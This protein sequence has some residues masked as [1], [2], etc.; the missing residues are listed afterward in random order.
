MPEDLGLLI[1]LEIHEQLKTKSKLFCT[2]S[3][4]YRD[5]E[6][7]HNI[8][9]VC[10]AQPGSKPMRLNAQALRNLLKIALALEC[11]IS[12][13]EEIIIQRKHYFYPDLPSNYQRTSEPIGTKGKLGNVRIRELHIEE[14]P[15]RY[16]L[17]KGTVDYNRSGVPLVEIVTEPDIR[18]PED[19]RTFLDELQA[20]TNYLCATR[21]EPGSTRIDANISLRGG[22]RVEVKNINSY[23]GV[24][25]ALKYEITRQKSLLE[26]GKEVVRETR[27]FD[28]VQGITTTL[29]KKEEVADY[30]YIPDPDVLPLLITAKEVQEISLSLPELPRAK[31]ERISQEYKIR[32]DDAWVLS[33]EKELIDAYETLAKS[34]DAQKLAF[35]MRGILKKQL[36][37]RNL[38]FAQSGLSVADLNAIAKKLFSNEITEDVAEQTLINILDKKGSIAQLAE[39]KV[40]A[41]AKELER[42]IF[43]LLDANPK[44]VQDYKRGEAKALNALSGLV[45][46][47]TQGRAD[48]R[49]VM[50]LLKKILG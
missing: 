9:A 44:I 37:Y 5:A 6:P 43:S 49:K 50:E 25:T 12:T 42:I 48:A 27:H 20:I 19:A 23:K 18:S 33:M 17:R 22:N 24:Y 35:F 41:D 47:K 4:S 28:E 31:A 14:D 2:C 26:R 13:G 32:M 45:M 1:G 38:S 34:L 8:C 36:N 15:G 39:M 7:N 29:R 46:K 30:R 21:D 16:E 40:I 10:T 11:E 3:A